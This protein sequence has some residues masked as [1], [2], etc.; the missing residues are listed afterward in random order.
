M[1][2]DCGVMMTDTSELSTEVWKELYKVEAHK[3]QLAVLKFKPKKSFCLH[4]F[5][6]GN[7]IIQCSLPT[8]LK[9]PV[10]LCQNTGMF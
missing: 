9:L 3:E 8:F 6:C 1:K 2:D 4:I 7:K 5:D 10:T